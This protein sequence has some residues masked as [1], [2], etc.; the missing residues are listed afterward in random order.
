MK[1]GPVEPSPRGGLRAVNPRTGTLEGTALA[2]ASALVALWLWHCWCVFP[3]LLWNELRLEPSF[4]LAHGLSV[5]PAPSDGPVTT[6]IYGPITPLLFLPAVLASTAATALMTAGAINL[7]IT[8]GA[9]AA[10]CGLWPA[11]VGTTISGPARWAAGLACLILWPSSSFQYIQADNPAVACGLIGCLI[12]VRSRSDAGWS[13]WVAAAIT[14]AAMGCKQ[15]ALGA[16][17]AQLIW[18]AVRDGRRI[19]L[20]HFIRASVCGVALV[21]ASVAFFDPAGLRL[22]LFTI[23][24]Q[25]P[26][27][28][29][30]VAR[31]RD[32]IPLLALHLGAPLV[33]FVLARRQIWQRESPF[34]LPA[35]C[36]V[37]ALP[38]GLASILK[39][40]GTLNSIQ[41][42]LL[43]LPPAL[44]VGLAVQRSQRW[45]P[46]A[47]LAGALAVALV[48][49]HHAPGIALLPR[50][51][52]LQQAET[53]ATRLPQE[54]WFPWNP[55]ITYF[56]AGR[57][58]H[59][60]DGL[61]VRFVA[62]QPLT[63]AEARAHLPPRW[64]AM[65]MLSGASDWGLATHLR[66]ADAKETRVG[67]WTLHTWPR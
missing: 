52:H 54:V 16:I 12:L 53:I 31:L 61:Y 30:W 56:S 55:L 6:W 65:A 51:T 4:L 58:D 32:L 49:L 39:I 43:F 14:V 50:I 24:G 46:T 34:L 5:Y 19:A 2:L 62:G 63:Q 36:W 26:W 59:V 1:A 45:L 15:T 21:L 11:P 22:N 37:A 38:P 47:F 8:V 28:D 57:F 67:F 44:V 35:L 27:T 29:E 33:V 23:P 17:V 18:L 41:S 3:W 9:V 13:R 25:L 48:R 60:E 40:G 7:L 10:V 66:P 42:L 20:R 64:A